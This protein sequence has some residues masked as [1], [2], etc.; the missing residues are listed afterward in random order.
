MAER[1]PTIALDFDGVIHKYS[2]GWG[3][4]TIYDPPMEGAFESISELLLTYNVVV[5]TARSDLPSVAAWFQVHDAD[6][7]IVRVWEHEKFWNGLYEGAERQTHVV[8]LTNRKLPADIYLDD[9]GVRFDSWKTALNDIRFYLRDETHGEA[10]KRR[11]NV[12]N[13]SISESQPEA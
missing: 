2:A 11:V 10:M 13:E 8:G 12:S 1:V 5:I 4:G 9:R 6:F 7:T 3:D